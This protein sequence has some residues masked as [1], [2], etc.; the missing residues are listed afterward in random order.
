MAKVTGPLLSFSASGTI[1]KAQ[2]YGRWR[3]VQYARQ[4]VIPANP[5][6]SGQQETRNTFKFL[7]NVWKFGVSQ[8][9]TPWTAAASGRPLTNRN[10]WTSNNLPALRGQATNDAMIFSPGANGGLIA[11]AATATGSAGTITGDM[12]PPVLPAGFAVASAIMVA[13][14]QQ[15][16]ASGT[17]YS[18]YEGEDAATPYAPTITGLDPGTYVVGMWFTYTAPGGKTAYGPS[19][20]TTA[21][22]T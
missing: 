10:L 6:T 16:P 8:M 20:T 7:Q 14:L 3:G 9:L 22:V 17:D 19:I 15:D 12:T 2:T 11:A 4:R 21:V 18:T 5:N 13:I 1:A